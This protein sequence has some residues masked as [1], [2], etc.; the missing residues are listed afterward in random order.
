M[1]NIVPDDQKLQEHHLDSFESKHMLTNMADTVYRVDIEGNLVYASP[2]AE[3]LT[4]YQLHELIGIKVTDLYM[5]PEKRIDFLQRLKESFGQLYNYEVELKHKSGHGVWVLINVQYTYDH[6]HNVTNIEGLI[7]D[8]TRYKDAEKALSTEREKAIVT[9]H[10]IADGVITTDISGK[11]DY[12]NPAAERITGWL[13]KSAH[14]K[15]I[16]EVFNPRADD[17]DDDFIHPVYACLKYGKIISTP[18]IRL[19]TGKNQREFAIR[20]SVSPIRDSLGNCIGAVLVFHDVSEIREMSRQLAYQATHDAQTGL[21]NRSE[22][23]K[24]L[25]HA[26][27]RCHQHEEEHVL[28]YLDLDQFKV[29]NDTCGHIAGD[30][31]LKQ[32]ANTMLTMIRDQDTFARLG[33]DEFGILIEKCTLDDGF[34]MADML[35]NAINNFRFSWDNKLFEIGASIGLVCLEKNSLNVNDVLS[36]ADAACFI[37]KDHGRN[38]IHVFQAD[39]AAINKQNKEMHWSYKIKHALE[40]NEFILYNQPIQCINTDNTDYPAYNEILVRMYHQGET[41]L[42]MAFIPA[43]ER[44]NQMLKIDRWVIKAFFSELRKYALKGKNDHRKQIFAI[45]LSGHSI[46]NQ[47]ILD[48]IIFEL[49][50]SQVDPESICFEITETAAISNL[51]YAKHFIQTLKDLGCC[52]ALDDFGSGLSSFNYLKYL[53]VDFLKIDGG[54]VRELHNDIISYSMVESINKVGHVMGLKTIAEYAETQDI[55]NDLKEIG[56]DYVQGVAIAI[57]KPWSLSDNHSLK[58]P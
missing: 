40:H 13:L 55:V 44:Y 49:K 15:N 35:R 53:P 6:D 50:K 56:V 5:N 8:I 51:D 19:L 11:I 17:N 48:F 26:I 52:F 2:A 25:N 37:A 36:M 9:L 47:D 38:R 57:P 42:P 3:E 27:Q 28:C 54:F 16:N 10:S 24:R 20:E 31:L 30:A 43:A 4:G 46:T 22:F 21:I 1:K 7:R 58:N 18:L 32:L 29:V 14:G 12:L 34:R 41:I 39:D 45:N 33:G 23:E